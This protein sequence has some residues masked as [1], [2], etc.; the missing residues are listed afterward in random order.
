MSSFLWQV[1]YFP[2]QCG[3]ASLSSLLDE[4]SLLQQSSSWSGEELTPRTAVQVSNLP[5]CGLDTYL[6]LPTSNLPTFIPTYPT[7]LNTYLG[8]YLVRYLSVPA[9]RT[10]FA[11]THPAYLADF[12]LLSPYSSEIS[13]YTLCARLE[14]SF[15]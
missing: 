3:S 11:S 1:S 4:T 8:T 9:Y 6:Y 12:L 7:D 15:S 14:T 10:Y 5:A 13:K 2:A